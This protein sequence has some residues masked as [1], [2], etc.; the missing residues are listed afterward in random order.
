MGA[1]SQRTTLTNLYLFSILIFL[2]TI[3]WNAS[4]YFVVHYSLRQP[5]VCIS[6]SLSLTC[7][8]TLSTVLQVSELHSFNKLN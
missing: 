5:W 1:T 8:V 7:C 2:S 4:F 3:E 6:L